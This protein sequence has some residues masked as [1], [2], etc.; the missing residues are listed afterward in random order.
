MYPGYSLVFSQ[1][2]VI[3]A[4]GC[5]AG[6]VRSLL[7]PIFFSLS[8]LPFVL[9]P[10]LAPIACDEMLENEGRQLHRIVTWHVAVAAYHVCNVIAFPFM[11]HYA[12]HL[13]FSGRIS[14]IILYKSR[15]P[16]MRFFWLSVSLVFLR[17]VVLGWRLVRR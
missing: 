5:T 9:V 8:L 10:L 4:F 6:G 14:D 7:P 16:C 17:P 13:E 11:T 2:I 12:I 3:N 1:N 15:V